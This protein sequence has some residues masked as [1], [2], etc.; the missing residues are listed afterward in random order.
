VGVLVGIREDA[1]DLS[2]RT[3]DLARN[4]AIEVFGRDDGEG[5]CCRVASEQTD[6]DED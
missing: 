2:I 4:I 6:Q 3:G 5:L 1:A